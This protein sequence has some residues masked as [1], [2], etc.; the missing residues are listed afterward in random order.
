MTDEEILDDI[1]RREGGYVDHQDDR[2]GCTNRGITITTLRAW[3]GQPVTCDDVKELTEYEARE[4]YRK[5]YLA[6]FDGLD[7]EVKPQVVDIAVNAGVA[8]ARQ[9]LARAQ[10]LD[11]PLPVALVV[12]RLLHYGRICQARPSQVVFLRGWITRACE[13]L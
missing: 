9:L 1:L 7:A 12:E 5:Q 10:Q 11:K 3:R 4:I 6:P 13:F 8:R 2:G